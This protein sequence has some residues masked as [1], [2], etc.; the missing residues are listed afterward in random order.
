MG[1][2]VVTLDVEDNNLT[3]SNGSKKIVSKKS[4]LEKET[5]QF[6]IVE[7]NNAQAKSKIK[8]ASDKGYEENK[9][10]SQR[11]GVKANLSKVDDYFDFNFRPNKKVETKN[12]SAKKVCVKETPTEVIKEK[13]VAETVILR[14]DAHENRGLNIAAEVAE[15][16]LDDEAMRVVSVA[17]MGSLFGCEICHNV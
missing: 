12:E 1:N 14:A 5:E 17:R 6:G 11:K 4:L 10:S 9:T 7:I 8:K 2:R 3:A 15:R 16:T 13:T